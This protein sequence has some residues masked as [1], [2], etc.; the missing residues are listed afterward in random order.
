VVLP[1]LPTTANGKTDHGGLARLPV[2]AEQTAP[3]DPAGPP[4][5][6]EIEATLVEL[7][8]T[9]LS[10]PAVGPH[11]NIFLN[12]GTSLTA[13]Q[14]AT[15]AS[16]R[17]AAPVTMAMVFRAPTPAALAHLIRAGRAAR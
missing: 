4:P 11:D 16:S 15:S 10:R 2:P 8:R 17:C 7:W 3:G 13:V 6:D 12:G 1:E 14:L 5:A 9:A